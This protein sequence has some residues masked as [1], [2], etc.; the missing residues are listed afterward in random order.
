[1]GLMILKPNKKKS[2]ISP[3]QS[4]ELVCTHG[5]KGL[6]FYLLNK[7]DSEKRS[8]NDRTFQLTQIVAQ[9]FGRRRTRHVG[10]IFLGVDKA[11]GRVW[12][13]SLR[14]KLLN[15]NLPLSLQG[16]FHTFLRIGWCSH[17]SRVP[18]PGTSQSTTMYHKV[19]P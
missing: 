18:H 2:E 11:F 15:L 10:A 17:L 6:T 4:R 14:Y 7:A 19:V 3:L 12:H 9:Q 13:N 1:M 8:V 5:L 16:G